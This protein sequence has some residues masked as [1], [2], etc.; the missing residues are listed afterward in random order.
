MRIQPNTTINLYSNVPIDNGEQLTFRSKGEQTSYFRSKLVRS[1]VECTVVK[2]KSGTLRLELSGSIVSQCNY[3]SFINPSFDNKIIYCKIV[4]YDYINNEIKYI[5]DYWQT[6]CFDVTFDNMFIEREHISQAAKN[7]LDNDP[8][9]LE[10]PEMLTAE[11]LPYVDAI[12]N[13]KGFIYQ[14][15]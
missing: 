5:I 15:L 1:N 9:S 4:D 10:V 12:E 11:N 7:L 14:W 13:P 8:Y 6:W 2:Q 3:L